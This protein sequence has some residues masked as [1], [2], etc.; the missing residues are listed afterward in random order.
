M[1]LFIVQCCS[2]KHGHREIFGEER[3]VLDD[4]PPLAAKALIDLR[5]RVKSA[6]ADKFG[7]RRLSSLA[8]YTGH[9]YTEATKRLLLV[10]PADVRFL[11]MSGGYGLLRPD[12]VIEKY[13]VHM[14]QTYSVWKAGLPAILDAYVRSNGISAVHGIVSRTSPYRRV[15]NVARRGGLPLT[16]H[17][18]RYTG[19]GALRAVP[20]LQ[21]K[22][23]GALMGSDRVDHVDGVPVERV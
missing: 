21:A 19:G 10:P 13:D 18:L 6:H 12:E 16:M 5:N 2:A 20:A 9:L 8:L 14:G 1:R 4:L 23:L 3:S 11:I 15:L 7:G 17:V 22:L